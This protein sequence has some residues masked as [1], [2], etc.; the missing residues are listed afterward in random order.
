MIIKRIPFNGPKLTKDLLQKP[1]SSWNQ[2]KSQRRK[3]TVGIFVISGFSLLKKIHRIK[4]NKT[5]VTILYDDKA[6]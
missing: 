4:K 5:R 6:L 2:I 3:R 1:Q